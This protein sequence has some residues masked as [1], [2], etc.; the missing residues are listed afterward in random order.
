MQSTPSSSACNAGL[1]G[2]PC[3]SG[4]GCGFAL[5]PVGV[6]L[7]YIFIILGLTRTVKVT[8]L[9]DVRTARLDGGRIGRL[10]ASVASL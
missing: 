5:C 3:A 1:R 6:C 4:L 9:G 2:V 10:L 7:I 8:R